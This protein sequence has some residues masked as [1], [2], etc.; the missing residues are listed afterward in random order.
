MENAP[1]LS[2]TRHRGLEKAKIQ[3]GLLAYGSTPQ[4][5]PSQPYF[6]P[7]ALVL[8]GDGRPPKIVL[9]VPDHSGGS[10]PDFHGIPC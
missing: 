3:A 1:S 9:R 2:P 6:R 10:V 8:P 4:N 7:V 5:K